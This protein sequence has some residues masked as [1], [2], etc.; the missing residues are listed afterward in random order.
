MLDRPLA[1][2]LIVGAATRLG[3]DIQVA[4]TAFV[5]LRHH[6]GSTGTGRRQESSAIGVLLTPLYDGTRPWQTSP[7]RVHA[8]RE[9]TGD[10]LS[11]H[12]E[13]WDRTTADGAVA[14]DA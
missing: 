9:P 6:E 3:R 13:T 10:D 2:Q 8:D 4:F 11:V 7:V 1:Q 14:D 5:Q 12:R